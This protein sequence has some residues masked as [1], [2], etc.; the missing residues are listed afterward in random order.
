LNRS[1]APTGEANRLTTG[2]NARAVSLSADGRRLAYAAF[3]ETSNVYSLPVPAGGP[4]SVSQA[5]PITSG[6]QVVETFDVS[7]DGHWLAFDSDRSGM[8]VIY[9]M[10]V[11]GG[12]PEQL[13]S[14]S[15]DDFWARWS[16]DGREIAYLTF[17][18]G[19]RRLMTMT[20]DGRNP[21]PITAGGVDERAAEWR[22]D[23]GGVYY[24]YRYD[25]PDPE[26]RFASRNSAGEWGRPTTIIKGDALPVSL[27]PNGR[28]LAF[29][30][31]AGLTL[32]GLSG[33]SARVLVPV[34]YRSNQLRPT[35]I[36]WAADSH[37]LYYLALDSLS[38]ASIWS[39]APPGGQPRLRV[40]F[41][42]PHREWH[43][44]GFRANGGRFYFTIGDRQSDIW[45]MTASEQR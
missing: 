18:G 40:R 35:Y 5:Q 27:S 13:T 31:S 41:D 26:V 23:G 17:R 14:D 4:A 28:W 36:S 44:Y 2:L 11:A 16:P 30:G 42:D 45:S 15:S 21:A 24:L 12:E 1:G 6:N 37:E 3:V 29:S 10:P 32:T 38:R 7:P 8:S 9:R 43:R 25:T 19:I 20:A 39:I 22:R 34:S 33:D